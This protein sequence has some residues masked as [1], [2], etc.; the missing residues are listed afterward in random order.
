MP[1][2]RCESCKFV[3]KNRKHLA[4]HVYLN[5]RSRMYRCSICAFV[6]RYQANF[7]RHRRSIHKLK[8]ANICEM[9]G[10]LCD[11]QDE[12]VAHT[13][14]EHPQF[15]D[16]LLRKLETKRVCYAMYAAKMNMEGGD[17]ACASAEKIVA[18]NLEPELVTGDVSDQI[19][20]QNGVLEE[21][22]ECVKQSKKRPCESLPPVSN[23]KGRTVRRTYTCAECGLVTKW[24]REFLSHRRDVHEDCI[25]IHECAFC[26]YASKEP[27]KLRRH[28]NIVHKEEMYGEKSQH[29]V[30]I[31][32]PAS[33]PSPSA[34]IKVH[35]QE[36]AFKCSSCNFH[37]KSKIHVEEHEKTVHLKRRFYRCQQCGYVCHE[38]GRYT[39]HMRFHS[40][41]KIKCQFC[42]FH[43]CYKWNMDWHL[44]CHT[45]GS[46][47]RCNKCGFMTMSRKSL[48]AHCLHHHNELLKD[49]TD[50]EEENTERDNVDD[51]E[52][53][54]VID[55]DAAEDTTSPPALKMTLK[56]TGETAVVENNEGTMGKCRYCPQQ[57]LRPSELKRHEETHFK[58]NRK[59]GCSLCH[60]RFDQLDHLEQ[61]VMLNHQE[62]SS[63]KSS[64]DANAAGTTSAPIIIELGKSDNSTSLANYSGSIQALDISMK[65]KQPMHVCQLCGYT[66]RWI[67]ALR[68][69]E[70]IHGNLK[71][72]KCTHCSFTSHWKGDMMRHAFRMHKENT[73]AADTNPRIVQKY[74]C[75]QCSFLTRPASHFHRHMIQ[76][77]NKRPFMCSVCSYRSNWQWDV[78][79]HIKS[80]SGNDPKHKKAR[81][82]VIDQTGFKNYE[83]YK[84]HLV[85]VEE[86]STGDEV[87]QPAQPSR[88]N[89]EEVQ[90]ICRDETEN[91]VVTSDIPYGD[92][93]YQDELEAPIPESSSNQQVLYCGHCNFNHTERK[94]VLSH[95]GSHASV[96]PYRCHLCNFISEWYHIVLMHVRHRHN[97]GPEHIE[98]NV[99]FVEEGNTFRLKEE[100]PAVPHALQ[101]AEPKILKCNTCPYQCSKVCHMKFHMKHH[102]PKEGA[103]YKCKYCPYYANVKKTLSRHMKLH[104]EEQQRAT[105]VLPRLLVKAGT[106][107]HACENCPYT[108]D[109]KTQYLYHKQFH[110]PNKNAPH[111]C[112]HCNYW[113]THRHLIVQ[114][115]KIHRSAD[116][117]PLDGTPYSGGILTMTTMVNGTA[118]RMFKCRFCPLT[119]K[120]RANV[121]IHERMHTALKGAKFQC[122]LCSY[123][124]SN[125]GVLASHMKLHKADYRSLDLNRM[126][127][128][129]ENLNALPSRPAVAKKTV[130]ESAAVGAQKSEISAL[131]DKLESPS[132][133]KIFSYCCDKCPAMFKSHYDLDTHKAYHKSGHLYPCHH[134]D[135]RARHKAHLHKHLLV[136]TP[137]YAERQNGFTLA[138]IRSQQPES[139]T[140]PAAP[141][142]A[143]QMLLLEKAETRAFVDAGSQSMG[144]QLHRCI[145]CPAAFQKPTTLEYHL[146]LH[147]STGV[148][149]CHFCNYA[150]NSAANVSTHTHLHYQGALK[151]K[152]PPKM[153]RCDKCPASFSKY[154]RFESHLT[155]H[156]RNERFR[157]SHCDYS[158]K[159]A[160]NLV[161][162]R[163]LHEVLVPES[164][165]P[166]V[167]P[168]A[169]LTVTSCP[170]P[171]ENGS[172]PSTAVPLSDSTTAATP[173]VVEEKCMYICSKCPY[174]FHR[175][176]TV[177]NHLQHH[178]TSEG[179]CCTFCDYR[180][181]HMSTLRDHTR[182]HFQPM[183]HYK[184]QAYM[185]CD[186][187]EIWSTA[188]DGT[189]TL[190]FQDLGDEKYFPE[191]DAGEDD[192]LSSPA[193]TPASSG[194]CSASMAFRTPQQQLDNKDLRPAVLKPVKHETDNVVLASK[195]TLEE[196]VS[197]VVVLNDKKEMPPGCKTQVVNIVVLDGTKQL[198]VVGGEVAQTEHKWKSEAGFKDDGRVHRICSIKSEALAADP[199]PML[200]AHNKHAEH[201]EFLDIT[202]ASDCELSAECKDMFLHSV[203]CESEHM[204]ADVPDGV[205][206]SSL[207]TDKSFTAAIET[208][209]TSE[210]DTSCRVK[211][212]EESEPVCSRIDS[213]HHPVATFP[214]DSPCVGLKEAAVSNL[215]N[216][217]ELKDCGVEVAGYNLEPDTCSRAKTQYEHDDFSEPS[218][219]ESSSGCSYMPASQ[220]VNSIS[221]CKSSEDSC[222]AENDCTQDGEDTLVLH[223][224]SSSL[225]VDA[226]CQIAV[227][228]IEADEIS[229]C[230]SD[231]DAVS[232]IV[233]ED[234]VEI[235]IGSSLPTIKADHGGNTIL[236]P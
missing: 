96:N 230:R 217:F 76:H 70:L 163:K 198:D 223:S 131:K 122:V 225:G 158:V 35:I 41:T 31:G 25:S 83:E 212:F 92:Q 128:F 135:Y 208:G 187:L 4:N 77:L 144:V 166:K 186:S 18:N 177:V 26:E 14:N 68:K 55:E 97:T 22:N 53:K 98:S 132:C 175:R 47:F 180:S 109:N 146:S 116:G 121:K 43:T 155:L 221:V 84:I 229:K 172:E 234:V 58:M 204:T 236:V 191:L 220:G 66:A 176:E 170:Q 44:K 195:E 33:S 75:P 141:A 21:Q 213:Q 2:Y 184:P 147:G 65:S 36:K 29:L 156:G 235:E 91:V 159:L 37:A 61:H 87:L 189:R 67:S 107:K 88:L 100:K 120:R 192:T 179:L 11:N 165:Q 218:V 118:Y 16:V 174:A 110:R 169:P 126:R 20:L 151:Q 42:N 153:F 90:L 95:L 51:D 127:T 113:S 101:N 62:E 134:C 23:K 3:G 99:S 57:V 59:H 168:P 201:T 157:C 210:S 39:S 200:K 48:T 49:A 232:C 193:S 183:H 137:E 209:V 130:P 148:Y 199:D 205:A 216:N 185:K 10:Q 8:R 211:K 206:T 226:H 56:R 81:L 46:E 85:D 173:A 82:V 224:V 45:S 5:H 104:K 202:E 74:K 78:K 123:R 71:A 160:A 7:H 161:K 64:S 1:S 125:T 194:S 154:N 102:V 129:C 152:Q 34:E 80:K 178:G 9:C 32:S 93:D 117:R 133:K 94:A 54:L 72:F 79:K 182:C 111:K 227:E 215:A 231:P 214:D 52:D 86:S 219:L 73:G 63:G 140:P 150:A 106:K 19:H 105:E 38:K 142:A 143:D 24:P 207:V 89:Q 119:N 139:A 115:Q 17:T 114:H 112:T 13:S 196:L 69:H 15:L 28:C 124:C 12:L 40:L 138:E 50:I 60:I 203:E 222:T 103:I 27:Q 233:P 197:N 30:K 6:T 228:E 145:C 149:A 188:S 171:P 167:E 108:S 181:T 164:K 162:H 190:V 136:H